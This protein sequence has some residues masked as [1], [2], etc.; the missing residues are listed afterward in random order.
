M[1]NLNTV[2]NNQTNSEAFYLQTPD[3]NKKIYYILRD[4]VNYPQTTKK[5]FRELVS[6]IDSKSID[7][8][9]GFF[10][11]L[12]KGDDFICEALIES[13]KL[14]QGNLNE[15]FTKLA[16]KDSALIF[17]QSN[18]L[19]DISNESLG[20]ALHFAV[21][22][23]SKEKNSLSSPAHIQLKSN[24]YKK[25]MLAILDE[26]ACRNIQIDDFNIGNA[27]SKA[28]ENGFLAAVEKCM[29]PHML[30]IIK[31]KDIGAALY[32]ATLHSHEEI[33]LAILDE[34]ISRDIQVDPNK[35]WF[36]NDGGEAFRYAAQN[37]LI[38][39]VERFVN[40]PLFE[41]VDPKQAQSALYLAKNHS[42]KEVVDFLEKS[43]QFI[44]K[45]DFTM[46]Y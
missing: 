32:Q 38:N 16:Q 44:G 41:T 21:D 42:H 28:A 7:Q 23:L 27:F 2:S 19:K 36:F 45:I 33:A 4:R 15:V 12:A 10:D 46:N 20:N 1:I 8:L 17:L 29:L 26:Y 35:S 6:P 14:S 5:N 11:R 9:V 25:I 40:S 3:V 30:K 43:D 31:D 39:F 22:Q 18:R 24:E 34:Y 37:G 13:P